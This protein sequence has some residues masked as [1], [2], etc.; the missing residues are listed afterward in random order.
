MFF[1]LIE[2]FW[3]YFAQNNVFVVNTNVHYNHSKRVLF[4]EMSQLIKDVSLTI[5]ACRWTST[6]QHIDT[7]KHSLQNSLKK[8]DLHRN[9]VHLLSSPYFK[10]FIYFTLDPLILL[11][12]KLFY[13]H[14]TYYIYILT[15]NHGVYLFIFFFISITYFKERHA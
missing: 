1:F 14:I 6:Y 3:N 12:R 2:K 15:G 10:M 8:N 7:Q 11:T 4:Y 9:I 13:S 5:T